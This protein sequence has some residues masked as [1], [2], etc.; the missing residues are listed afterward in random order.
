MR[1]TNVGVPW[2]EDVK[3][4][5]VKEYDTKNIVAMVLAN[6]LCLKNKE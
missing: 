5:Y 6:I 2:N 4:W 1:V 3:G